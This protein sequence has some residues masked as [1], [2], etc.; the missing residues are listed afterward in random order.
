MNKGG[1]R[2]RNDKKQYGD[3]DD[4]FQ[5]KKFGGKRPSPIPGI[6]LLHPSSGP[7][8]VR[9]YFNSL[10]A[11]IKADKKM[12]PGMHNI[13]NAEGAAY[14]VVQEVN[15]PPDDANSVVLHK[16]K[17][18]YDRAM[19]LT[20]RIA[21]NRISIMGVIEMTISEQSREKALGSEEGREALT[22]N[23]PLRFISALTATHYEADPDEEVDFLERMREFYT[24]QQGSYENIEHYTKRFE[25]HM[26]SLEHSAVLNGMEDSVPDE[27][28]QVSQYIEGL[29]G[30]YGDYKNNVKLKML[31]KEDSIENV[32]NAAK[33]Y[34]ETS[35]KL[36]RNAYGSSSAHVL[37][38]RASNG[39]NIAR[40]GGASATEDAGPECYNCRKR[41]HYAWQCPDKKKDKGTN[42][43]DKK[44]VQ[45]SG[46]SSSTEKLIDDV[47]SSKQS[48]KSGNK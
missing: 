21:E 27:D 36:S 41:G 30:P 33:T 17:N 35:K 5:K 34:L 22:T 2:R 40:D 10:S 9:E 46:N 42:Y 45:F 14:P 15:D 20:T 25:A 44:K 31:I 23:D 6:Y 48:G 4:S 13:C 26:K 1:Q 8:G 28:L 19:D 12:A 24:F 37:A 43:T 16:W 32:K 29:S 39:G 7:L 38:V 3:R 11:Y 47:I 18:E